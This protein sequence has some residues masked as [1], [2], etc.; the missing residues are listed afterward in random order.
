MEIQASLWDIYDAEKKKQ[1]TDD[2]KM[3][4]AYYQEIQELLDEK[5]KIEGCL[6]D[7]EALAQKD[8]LDDFND[9]QAHAAGRPAAAGAGASGVNRSGAAS[10]NSRGR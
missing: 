4:S 2:E 8:N 6:I 3:N 5:L 10:Q 9:A 7:A 1:I